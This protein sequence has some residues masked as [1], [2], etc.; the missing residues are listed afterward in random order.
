V[1]VREV[2]V[3]AAIRRGDQVERRGG[4]RGARSGRAAFLP[5]AG[6][7]IARANGMEEDRIRERLDA[8]D[9]GEIHLRLKD[10][11]IHR[12]GKRGT[13]QA[14]DL[15]QAAITRLYAFDSKW[16]PEKEPDVLRTLMSIVNGLLRNER[17]SAAAR[18]TRSLSSPSAKRAAANVPDASRPD[19]HVADTDLLTR[20]LALLHDRCADD[21]PVLRMV[22]LMTAGLDSPAEIR[23]ATGWTAAEFA[24]TRRRMLRSA[25]RVARDLGCDFEEGRLHEDG[26]DDDDEEEGGLR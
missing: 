21:P 3:A 24:A 17:T 6:P 23:A 2:V 9:W 18:T 14:E 1:T 13:A 4:K 16:D 12:C 25:A 10:F 11:A 20:R 15:V 22:S 7:C 19:D 5:A 8:Q 26:A